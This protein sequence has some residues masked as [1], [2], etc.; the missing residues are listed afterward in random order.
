MPCGTC[1]V[2]ILCEYQFESGDAVIPVQFP[3]NV[4]EKTAE[5]GT[6]TRSPATYV[7]DLDRVPGS[8]LLIGLAW[9]CHCGHLGSKP[10]E[11]S[12]TRCKIH[13]VS[14]TAF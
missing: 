6:S 13:I 10:V 14:V 5:D 12:T 4:P 9:P 11:K 1:N 2:C 8:W 7:D 3:L